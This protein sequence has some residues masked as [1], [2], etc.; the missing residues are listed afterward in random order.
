[1]MS[2]SKKEGWALVKALALVGYNHSVYDTEQRRDL[3]AIVAVKQETESSAES[4]DRGTD[5]AYLRRQEK[6]FNCHLR[7]Y[8]MIAR[9]P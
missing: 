7:K 8:S 6:V 2:L 9:F 3:Q 4:R 5:V 1:M